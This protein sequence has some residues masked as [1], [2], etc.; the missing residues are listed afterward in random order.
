MDHRYNYPFGT[1][2]LVLP[3][4]AA[5]APL[6]VLIFPKSPVLSVSHELAARATRA[7]D[8][9]GNHTLFQEVESVLSAPVS[10]PRSP[11]STETGRKWDC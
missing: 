2:G 4:A 6:P 5:V 10:R 9:G 7:T 11:V 3:P 8:M 1:H